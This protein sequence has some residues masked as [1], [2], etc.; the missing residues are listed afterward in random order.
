MTAMVLIL[1]VIVVFLRFFFLMTA[2]VLILVGIAVFLRLFF[3]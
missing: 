3:L 2:T 1:M